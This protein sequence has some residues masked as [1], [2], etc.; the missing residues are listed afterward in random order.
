MNMCSHSMGEEEGAV[1]AKEG[2]MEGT[3]LVISS[4]TFTSGA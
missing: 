2:D 4:G 1:G 3:L